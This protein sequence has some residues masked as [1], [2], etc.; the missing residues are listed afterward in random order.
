MKLREL[1]QESFLLEYNRQKTA[2]AFGGKLL[3]ALSNDI[4]SLTDTLRTARR[5]I[6]R[7]QETGDQLDLTP[8]QQKNIINVILSE[9]E[10]RDPTNNKQYSQWIAKIYSNG[11]TKFEEINPDNELATY[12]RGRQ[13]NMIKPEYTDINQFKSYAEFKT[14]LH[15]HDLDT[16]SHQEEQNKGDATTVFENDQVRIVVPHDEAA[17]CYYGRGTKWCTAGNKDNRFDDYEDGELYILIP[18]KPA[19]NGEKY[20]MYFPSNEYENEI[21]HTQDPMFLMNK[22]FG[23]LQDVFLKLEPKLRETLCFTQ[24]EVIAQFLPIIGDFA[25]QHIYDEADEWEINDDYYQSYIADK[26]RN[27]DGETDYENIEE[28]DYY[29]E[30]NHEA[31]RA[32][33]AA[34]D[35]VTMTP[36]DVKAWAESS[37]IIE[38]SSGIPTIDDI[39]YI[40]AHNVEQ[41]CGRYNADF[42]IGISKFI[43]DH[44][45]IS[46]FPGEDYKLALHQ[47]GVWEVV[48]TFPPLNPSQ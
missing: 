8:D 23:N 24:D 11:N 20:Q 48:Q 10:T 14:A 18:K 36:A 4:G 12:F 17:A 9:L 45:Y 25:I 30:W 19:Y 37:E 29:L 47:N 15:S 33:S 35:A 46:A 41:E 13:R 38:L 7:S 42:A 31:G 6:L 39:P 5:I 22:R 16:I 44:V 1:F 34:I 21:K 43:R 2:D 27:E 28:E 26:Y 40:M 32:V 3:I